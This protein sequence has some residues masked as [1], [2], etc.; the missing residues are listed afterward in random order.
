MTDLHD[1]FRRYRDEIH[2]DYEEL[3]EALAEGQHPTTM[4]IAC[5]DSRIDTSLFTQTDPGELFVVRNAGNI[6]PRYDATGGGEAATIE[7][8]VRVLKVSDIIVCGHSHCGAMHG[9]LHR[10]STTDLPMVHR[11]LH[12]A[13]AARPPMSA[14]PDDSAVLAETA[15]R[16]VRAQLDN[17][18]THPCVSEAVTQRRLTLH[19]WFYVFESGELYVHSPEQQ[20]FEPID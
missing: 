2:A 13:E 6:V 5:S 11:W 7:Y 3:F 16:N 9:L 17:L 8:A 12:H 19:G 15:K 14:D 18:M 1:G 10:D 4:M 20:A